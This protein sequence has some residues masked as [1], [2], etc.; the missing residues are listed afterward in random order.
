MQ[1]NLCRNLG[2]EIMVVG[3]RVAQEVL[4]FCGV[5]LAEELKLLWQGNTCNKSSEG[6]NV[7][8]VFSPF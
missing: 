8:T 2:D 4:I 6:C 7:Y 5:L 3:E 1:F